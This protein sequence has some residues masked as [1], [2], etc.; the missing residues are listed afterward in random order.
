M[1]AIETEDILNVCV[2]RLVTS[3]GQEME[4]L[5]SEEAAFTSR[6]ATQAEEQSASRQYQQLLNTIKAHIMYVTNHL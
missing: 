3:G 6:L 4:H 5:Q 2:Y 1:Y